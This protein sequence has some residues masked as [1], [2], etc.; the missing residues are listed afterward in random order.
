MN[1]LVFGLCTLL[2]VCIVIIFNIDSRMTE[3]FDEIMVV[4]SFGNATMRMSAFEGLP[5]L[6]AFPK[7][8]FMPVNS[9]LYSL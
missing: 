4:T 7:S 1:Y 5:K 6:A 3:N 8:P 2:F 9:S